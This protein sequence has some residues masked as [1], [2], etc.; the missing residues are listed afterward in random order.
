MPVRSSECRHSSTSA[1]VQQRQEL[2]VDS[3]AAGA[4]GRAHGVLN[5]SGSSVAVGFMCITECLSV[6]ILCLHPDA[7]VLRELLNLLDLQTR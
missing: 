1:V 3:R 5:Q 7:A 4:E 2:R 6:Q